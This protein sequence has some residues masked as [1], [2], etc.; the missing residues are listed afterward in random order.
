MALTPVLT[1]HWDDPKSFEIE[2]YKKHGGYVAL[3]EFF[4]NDTR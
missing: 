1:A 4:K 2:S 3:K